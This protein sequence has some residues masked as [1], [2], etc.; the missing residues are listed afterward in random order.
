VTPR[1]SFVIPAFNADRWI[2]KT[3]WSCRNQ[4]IKQIEIIIVNDGSTDG[5]SDILRWHASEDSRIKIVE[6]ENHGRSF[7]RNFGNDLVQSDLILVLDA[8]DMAT[9]NRVKDTLA[10][11]ELKKPDFL[12]GS[13]FS[14]DAMGTTQSKLLASPF[15][16]KV[17]KEKKLNFICHS[18]VA[19][20]KKLSEDVRYQEGDYTKLGLDDWQFQWEVYRKGYAIRHIKNPLCYYRITDDGTMA[21]RDQKAVSAAK[22]AYLATA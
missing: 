21:T 6:Q 11:F 1:A 2:S 19:Y 4:I 15:D 14:V 17:S 22:D 18:T 10:V 5:T 8:D 7:S 20:T 16:P 3:I 12:Y 13:F 9:R